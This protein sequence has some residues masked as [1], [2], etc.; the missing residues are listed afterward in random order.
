LRQ[1]RKARAPVSRMAILA[2]RVLLLVPQSRS[3]GQPAT[4]RDSIPRRLAVGE[5]DG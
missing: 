1:C 5:L 4:L 2:T 3:R